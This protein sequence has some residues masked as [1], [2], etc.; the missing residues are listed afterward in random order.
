M[1]QCS[2]RYAEANNKYLDSYNPSE[3]SSYIV[4]LDCNN[5]YGFAMIMHLPRDNFQWIFNPQFT[6]EDIMN[7][8]DDAPTGYIFEVDL[9]YPQHLHDIHNDFPFCAENAV[10]PNSRGKVKKLL[11]CVL[12]Y[13][14]RYFRALLSLTFQIR[15]NL[16]L[17]MFHMSI[18]LCSNDS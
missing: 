16:P 15:G 9:Q 13:T 2:K 6:V 12:T 1:S 5:L 7:L 18:P 17:R 14:P 8:V 4:Y 10:P 3:E 11:C